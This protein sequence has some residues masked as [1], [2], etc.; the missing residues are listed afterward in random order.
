[1]KKKLTLRLDKDVIEQAK[2]Y[3]E[4][5]NVSVSQLV[6]NYF[7]VLTQSEVELEGDETWREHLPPITRSLVGCL[8]GTEIDEED[9]YRYLE[10]KYLGGDAL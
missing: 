10:Q 5:Q 2:G 6:E 3:A 4:D 1:M 8:K 7:R 9:Y